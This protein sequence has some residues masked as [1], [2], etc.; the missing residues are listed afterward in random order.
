MMH[1]Y[2]STTVI[3]GVDCGATGSSAQ[4][5]A[6]S[7]VRSTLRPGLCRLLNQWDLPQ[8]SSENIIGPVQAAVNE[9]RESGLRDE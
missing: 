5:T 3:R 4:N 8:R 9:D 7:S 1:G 6:G 2:Q